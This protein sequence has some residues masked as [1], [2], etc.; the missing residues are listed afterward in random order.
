MYSVS[1]LK[2]FRGF[3]HFT[4]SYTPKTECVWTA[5]QVK[6]L[7]CNKDFCGCVQYAVRQDCF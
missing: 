1:N 6:N 5:M 2:F 7:M 3:S 4:G